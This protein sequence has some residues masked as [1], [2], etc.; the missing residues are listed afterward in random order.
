MLDDKM[1]QPKR[2]RPSQLQ[3]MGLGRLGLSWMVVCCSWFMMTLAGEHV[4]VSA[5]EGSSKTDV[6][7]E[8]TARS[9]FKAHCFHCHG[10][11][12]VVE[13]GLD[14]RLRH[15]I[16]TGGDSGP[17]VVPGEADQ[18]L[19]WERMSSG[20][21]PPEE[22]TIRPSANE[23]EIVRRWISSGAKTV[24]PEPED[25]DDL[26]R[27]T[28]EERAF[29]AFQPIQ[30][31]SPPTDVKADVL[32]RIRTPIDAFILQRL[33][34]Q[35]R[36]FSD[37]AEK[38]VLI[39]R[40]TF[41]LI[42]LP[43]TPKEINDF[44]KDNSANA[45]ER[46]IDRLLSSPRYGERWGRHWLDVVGYADSEGFTE[47]DAT[48][49]YAYKYRDY[50]IQALNDNMP[51]DQF[52]QEQIAGD[53]LISSPLDA[54]TD[55][56]RRRL[57]AT[58]FLRMAPDGTG[59]GADDLVAASNAVVTE[60][61]NIVSTSMM[62]MTVGCAQCHDHRFDP[63]L[64]NDFYRIR[65]V[66]EPALNP[67]AWKTPQQRQIPLSESDPTNETKEIKKRLDKAQAAHKAREDAAIEMVF[68]RELKKIPKPLREDARNAFEASASSRTE[69]QKQLLADYP[70]LRVGR[71]SAL[72]LYLELF[73][74]GRQA[75]KELEQLR[76]E[77]SKIRAELP[78][79]DFIRGITETTDNLPDTFIFHRG[80]PAQPTERVVPG[81]LS[82]LDHLL[83]VDFEENASQRK[84]TGRR[85]A[86][87]YHLTHADN[88]LTARVLVNRFWMHH[89]GRGIVATPGD[90]GNQGEPPSHPELL[91][92]LARDFVKHGWDLKRLHKLIMTS[93]VYR[94]DSKRPADDFDP[95]NRLFGRQSIRRLEAE[96]IRDSILF[97]S[98]VLAAD[99]AGPATRV[100]QTSEGQTIV[101]AD[102]DPQKNSRRSI[103]IQARRSTPL[104]MLEVFDAPRLEPNCVARDV[105]TV[106]PQSLMLMNS[107]MIV[108]QSRAFAQRLLLAGND[109]DHQIRDAWSIAFGVAPTEPELTTTREFLL[110]QAEHFRAQGVKSPAEKALQSLCMV[111]MGSNRFLYVD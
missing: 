7:F 63:I 81:G 8:H 34:D 48:R 5:S 88:P 46:V 16:V 97:V 91:D 65:A 3:R 68:Q 86:F 100:Q 60:T 96:T 107:E 92:W 37:E 27:I 33:H 28:P 44:V 24:R 75:K 52:I 56:D 90:F 87:A 93:T 30:D 108:E 17:A 2:N 89:F 71:G 61:I 15:L 99:V 59:S 20:E 66:F 105:S 110:K 29:W 51:F 9:V 32:N 98:G 50:V 31:P 39:R 18:S 10:E 72:D 84:S 58:G 57:V 74:E 77:V 45:W 67:Q 1:S 54:L 64:H 12:G 70:N 6:A 111:M 102:I 38:R 53:E 76:A 55:E 36:G 21:M 73:D 104:A 83:P 62:G 40:A 106:T 26:P 101:D 23:I 82:V 47:Q 19:L 4:M 69:K 95:D 11:S 42:G 80:D 109:A 22:V 94:Q 103:Y 85:L 78:Q 43:P 13:G 41:D 79:Q 49:G 14:L 35:G 25:P